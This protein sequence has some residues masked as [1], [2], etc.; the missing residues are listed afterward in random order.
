MQVS[1]Y[2]QK[3][4]VAIYINEGLHAGLSSVSSQETCSTENAIRL[5]Q[6]NV[7][8]SDMEGKVEICRNGVWGD[9]CYDNWDYLDAAVVC[10]QLGFSH[11]GRCKL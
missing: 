7:D 10:R 11:Y 8:G 4:Y 6:G 1:S 2:Q 5:E 9:V 3:L